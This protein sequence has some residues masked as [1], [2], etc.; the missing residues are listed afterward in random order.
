MGFIPIYFLFVLCEHT[1]FLPGR[2]LPGPSRFLHLFQFFLC[3]NFQNFQNI[4]SCIQYV[5]FHGNFQ[6]IRTLLK[7]F[8]IFSIIYIMNEKGNNRV[9]SIMKRKHLIKLCT[10]RARQFSHET[11]QARWVH[12]ES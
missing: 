9:D 11:R 5:P 6:N 1:F 2:R 7:Y 4:E 10:R 12:R 3:R 8:Q